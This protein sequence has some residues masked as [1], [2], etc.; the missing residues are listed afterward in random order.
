[1]GNALS[2]I[3][4]RRQLSDEETAALSFSSYFTKEEINYLYNEFGRINGNFSQISKRTIWRQNINYLF[5]EENEDNLERPKKYLKDKEDENMEKYLN[6]TSRLNKT[7]FVDRLSD[8]MDMSGH[9]NLDVSDHIRW[10]SILTRG[11]VE[12]RLAC[13]FAI[14]DRGDGFTDKTTIESV[15][16]SFAEM[17]GKDG[18]MPSCVLDDML[19]DSPRKLISR[20]FFVA[21]LSADKKICQNLTALDNLLIPKTLTDID[22]KM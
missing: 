5:S 10:S 1:M 8:R 20:D 6:R 7:D 18:G 15:R 12:Q 13:L 4:G 3:T 9:G 21:Y 2:I 19:R 22:T 16:K 11:N 17:I 14:Y